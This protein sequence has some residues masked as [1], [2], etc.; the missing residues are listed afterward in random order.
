M[1]DK[2]ID[3]VR[4]GALLALDNQNSENLRQFLRNYVE[5]ITISG[6]SVSIKFT[7]RD[8]PESCQELVA[9][10]GF[11]PTTFGL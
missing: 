8:A 9:G 10:V 11:E 2:T 5:G 1:D 6:E 3:D 7:F 4:A